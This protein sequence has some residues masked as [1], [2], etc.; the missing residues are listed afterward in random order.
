[1][2]TLTQVHN[3]PSLSE[4]ADNDGT[5]MNLGAVMTRSQ[6]CVVFSR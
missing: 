3:Q 2:H 5:M 4:A 6:T 1:M